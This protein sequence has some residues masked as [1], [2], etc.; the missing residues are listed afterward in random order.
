MGK[1]LNIGG[2]KRCQYY[3]K[4]MVSKILNEIGI[5]MPPEEFFT[6]FFVPFFIHKIYC[7]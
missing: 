3:Y 4:D 6:K 1:I 2:G 7:G 5:G